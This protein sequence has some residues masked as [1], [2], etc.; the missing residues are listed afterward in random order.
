MTGGPNGLGKA[1]RALMDSG[2][3]DY[4]EHSA[5]ELRDGIV[6]LVAEQESDYLEYQ[7]REIDLA[8]VRA[9]RLEIGDIDG[10]L[11][12]WLARSPSTA[13]LG[14]TC[15][16]LWQLWSPVNPHPPIDPA[17]VRC[18][19]SAAAEVVIGMNEIG[20]YRAA[21]GFGSRQVD[22]PGTL[23]AINQEVARLAIAM[24]GS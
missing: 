20:A 14:V 18:L 21:L 24:N 16:A 19:I 12:E 7:M 9:M 6:E 23:A 15:R 10:R 1:A 8:L 3:S 11:I 17:N 2:S 13:R 22:D 4:A 5:S